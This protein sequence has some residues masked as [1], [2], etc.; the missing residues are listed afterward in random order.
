MSDSRRDSIQDHNRNVNDATIDSITDIN[1]IDD[2]ANFN[3]SKILRPDIGESIHIMQLNIEGISTSKCEFLE[4]L[5]YEEKID[6]V[7]HRPRRYKICSERLQ[8]GQRNPQRK[9]WH[10]YLC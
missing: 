6:I 10:C 4:N 2:T 7:A 1:W 5:L 3:N 9:I 8:Y